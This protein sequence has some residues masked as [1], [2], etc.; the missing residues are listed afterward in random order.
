[1]ANRS[2][3][4][5]HSGQIGAHWLFCQRYGLWHPDHPFDVYSD[6]RW[7]VSRYYDAHVRLWEAHYYRTN[8]RWPGPVTAWEPKYDAHLEPWNRLEATRR[9][10][11]DARWRWAF[12]PRE[13]RRSYGSYDPPRREEIIRAW[14]SEN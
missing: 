1:M 4:Y 11:E 2:S 5:D 13:S 7:P 14:R 8:G 3:K 12:K 6:F 9:L 10:S